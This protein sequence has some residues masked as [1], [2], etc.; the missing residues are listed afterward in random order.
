MTEARPGDGT[1]TQMEEE[2]ELNHDKAI[3]RAVEQIV[4]KEMERLEVKVFYEYDGF[5]IEFE[6]RSILMCVLSDSQAL[7]Q[8][9][10]FFHLSNEGKEEGLAVIRNARSEITSVIINNFDAVEH[11]IPVLVACMDR[12]MGGILKTGS[13]VL[14]LPRYTLMGDKVITTCPR[15]VPPVDS[16]GESICGV[17]VT[18]LLKLLAGRGLPEVSTIS[19]RLLGC[20]LLLTDS[21]T[22]ESPLYI[23]LRMIAELRTFP[24]CLKLKMPLETKVKVLG[25]AQSVQA[26]GMNG[27]SLVEKIEYAIHPD[28]EVTPLMAGGLNLPVPVGL[29]NRKS[30]T[31]YTAGARPLLRKAIADLCDSDQVVFTTMVAGHQF[32]D[33]VTPDQVVA[34]TEGPM[35]EVFNAS[36]NPQTQLLQ[37]NRVVSVQRVSGMLYKSFVT[38]LRS[39]SRSQDGLGASSSQSSSRSSSMPAT[40]KLK[41]KGSKLFG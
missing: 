41:V 2:D 7:A 40:K 1:V 39:S 38:A 3:E 22:V 14:Q 35:V 30:A 11:F 20:T 19:S 27:A 4:D 10:Q 37:T 31:L 15:N 6:R 9:P 34:Y 23:G 5:V 28:N 24:D 26:T 25:L 36:K 12:N 32:Y 16:L 33:R 29:T 13:I 18:N 8:E 17:A 21:D